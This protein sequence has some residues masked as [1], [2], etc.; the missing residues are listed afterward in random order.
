MYL[1]FIRFNQKNKK[2]ID[3]KIMELKE[4]IDSKLVN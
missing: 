3:E 4:Y 2:Y 1:S